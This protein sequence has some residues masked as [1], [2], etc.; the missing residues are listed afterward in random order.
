MKE[1]ERLLQ[2]IDDD[3]YDYDDDNDV[4]YDDDDDFVSND[5]EDDDRW[6]SV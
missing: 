6:H 3:D 5:D 2:E 1:S 4:S